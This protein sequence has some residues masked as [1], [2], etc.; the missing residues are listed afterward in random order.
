MALAPFAPLEPGTYFIDPDGDPSTSLRVV[1]EIAAKGWEMWIGAAKFSD[2]GHAGLSITTVSNLVT[3][4]CSDHSWASPPVG[5]SVKDLA[6]AL[7]NLPPFRVTSPPTD[8]SIYGY[9]GKH[10][11]WIVP[12]LPVEEEGSTAI[13]PDASPAT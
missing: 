11:E 8:V 2:V 10:L 1:Y 9:S 12:D 5:P 7:A 6:A 4:G 3:D 13:S